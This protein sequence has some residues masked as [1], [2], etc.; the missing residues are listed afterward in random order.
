MFLCKLKQGLS[1]DFL[2]LIFNYNS[3]QAV[4]MAISTVRKS[5]M[6]RFVSQNIG[7]N[8]IT[9][10][11]YI[12]QHVTEFANTLYNEKENVRKVIACIDGTYSYIEIQAIFKL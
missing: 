8:A 12:Q 11:Q 9:R 4:S 2:K 1:D 3:R 10:E 5:L 6:I 7:L